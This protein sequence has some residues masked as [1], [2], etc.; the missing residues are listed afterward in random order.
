M[1]NRVNIRVGSVVLGGQEP[2]EGVTRVID[3]A[4]LIGDIVTSDTGVANKVVRGTSGAY[5]IGVVVTKEKDNL[6]SVQS[7]HNVQVVA[8]TGTLILGVTGLQANG[9]GTAKLVAAG[10]ASS[11][12]V[13]VLGSQT[14]GGVTYIALN[15][16]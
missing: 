12:L 11:L 8:L 4:A 14:V 16:I 13:D 2:D 3:A 9:D 15:R 10:T 1:A 5:P 6:G 7:F